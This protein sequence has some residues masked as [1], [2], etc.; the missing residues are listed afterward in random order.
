MEAISRYRL[1]KWVVRF[2]EVEDN[3]YT[4]EEY[5]LKKGLSEKEYNYRHKQIYGSL[6]KSAKESVGAINYGFSEVTFSSEKSSST[7]LS[8]HFS[9]GIKMVLERDFD[10]VEFTRAVKLLAELKSC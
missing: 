3:G 4:V 2:R 6:A 7:G 8:I 9:G 10:D 5:C 1:L